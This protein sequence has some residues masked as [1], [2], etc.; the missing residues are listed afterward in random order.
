MPRSKAAPK[1]RRCYLYTRVSS[2]SQVDGYSLDAQRDRLMQKAASE[3]MA[4]VAEFSDEGKSG[5]NITGR[6]QFMAML[7]RIQH[8]NPDKV[9][10]VMV[11]KLS[12]FGRNTADVLN[13][14]QAMQKRGV[15]LIA[16][17]DGIDS[18]KDAGKLMVSV[19]A[20]VAEI[21][22]DNIRIQSKAGQLQKA[23]EGGWNGGPAPLGYRIVQDANGRNSRLAVD[24]DEAK[25]I[26]LIFD[27]YA[28]TK[29]GYSGVAKWLN[30]NGYRRPVPVNGKYSS[31]TDRGVK[32]ILDNPVYTGKIVYG[33]FGLEKVQDDED[34]YRHVIRSQYDS[35]DGL[36]EAIIS[37]ELWEEVQ[38]KRRATAG[39]PQEHYGPSHVHVLS[40]IVRCPACGMPMHG[41]VS[42]LKQKGPDGVPLTKL[43]YHCKHGRHST[44]KT[45]TYNRGIREDILDKQVVKVVQQ[46]VN[47]MYFEKSLVTAFSRSEDLDELAANLD[48]LQTEKKAIEKKKSRLLDRIER[49]DEDS[50]QYDATFNDLQDVLRRHNQ[51]IAE[52]DDQ[53]E[54]TS[55]RLQTA[56]AGAASFE[57][58]LRMFHQSMGSIENWPAG[59]LR[60]FMHNFLEHVEVYPQPLP[61]GR[62]V[63]S[64][65]FKFPVSVDGGKTYGETVDLDSGDD[66]ETDPPSGGGGT[67]DP[68]NAPSGGGVFLT[69][70]IL[71]N[72]YISTAIYHALL[73]VTAI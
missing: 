64:I 38:A 44:G 25:L 43:Y 36:H 2:Q 14:L 51:S 41:N 63:K 21:E 1:K 28:H 7:D 18:S 34:E 35:Y 31:F 40:G 65:R 47:N 69:E 59:H 73:P 58:T 56:R 50:G 70:D 5:K 33:R 11:F 13:S 66:D 9:N 19:L 22:R 52:L 46:A 71:P 3:N 6:P 45:C 60:A 20:A 72:P 30:R 62:Q 12:R 61:D 15:E 53:I 42:R 67:P 26:R 68:G 48:K 55:V 39:K 4:V 16:V 17:E 57:D 54:E 32:N 27:K 29:M 24:E 8:G 23:K 37:D 49:L 10:Y